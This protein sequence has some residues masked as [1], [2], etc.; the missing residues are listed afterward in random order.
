M[1]DAREYFDANEAEPKPRKTS[2]R[3]RPLRRADAEVSPAAALAY[4]LTPFE[5]RKLRKSMSLNQA[6]FGKLVGVCGATICK[7]ETGAW[8][9]PGYVH[10]AS[11][12]L[13]RQMTYRLSGRDAPPE[14]PKPARKRFLAW[15]FPDARG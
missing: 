3:Q 15:L 5:L 2:A 1:S 13:A 6:A 4:P 9:V 11:Q 10:E 8:P 12:R 14:P 7:Y